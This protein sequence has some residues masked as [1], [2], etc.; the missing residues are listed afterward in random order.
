[1]LFDMASLKDEYTVLPNKARLYKQSGSSRFYVRIKL[2]NGKWERRATGTEDLE[3]AKEKAVELYFRAKTLGEH[4]LPQTT[5]TFSG[6]AK[7]IVAELKSKKDTPDWKTVYSHYISAIEKHQIPFF[8]N[9]ALNNIKSKHSGYL[10]YFAQ[11]LG[12]SPS[13]STIATHNSALNLVFRKAVQAGYMKQEDVPTLTTGGNKS[14]R[15]ATFERDEYMKLLAAFRAWKKKPTHRA[16]DAEIRELL[17]NYII[18][19]ANTG[20]RPGR[21]ALDL[22]WQNLS[23]K[24][25]SDGNKLIV[26]RVLKKKGRESTGEWRDVIM[27]DEGDSAIK[28]LNRL[29]NGQK[30]LKKITLER[31]VKARNP[32]KIFALNDGSQPASMSPTFRKFLKDSNLLIGYEGEERSL[33]SWRHFYATAELTRK[34]PSSVSLLAQQMGTSIAMLEKHYGHLDVIKHGDRLSGRAQR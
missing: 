18:V 29:K 12:K 34:D 1:M 10:P 30:S 5:R 19:L 23:F 31:L 6:I 28:V 27:R 9:V 4:N 33:Y 24:K 21:E 14:Q 17:Y 15:R 7:S 25:S 11:R 22:T 13:Q 3:K 20:I 2:D 26:F 16:K 32:A 8:G